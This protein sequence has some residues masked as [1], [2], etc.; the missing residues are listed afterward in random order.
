M[1]TKTQVKA[2][3]A[4]IAPIAIEICKSKSRKVLP[5]VCIAQACCE[6]AYGTSAKMVN[7]NAIFGIKVGKSKAHF[8]TAWHDK[9]YSTKTKECYDGKTYV[10]ITDMFRAYDTIKDSV[11]DYYDMLGTCS[12]YKACIGETDAVKCITAIKNGG[13]ATSPTY[14]STI[15][16]ITDANN[17][18]QYD[19]CMTK[20][21]KPDIPAADDNSEGKFSLGQKVKV[22]AY[23]SNSTASGTKVTRTKNLVIKKILTGAKH[24]YLVYSGNTAI[25]WTEEQYMSATTIS[26]TDTYVYHTVKSGDTNS[27][28]AKQYG[29]TVANILSMNK[30]TY[31]T[32]SAGFLSVGWKLRVK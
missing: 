6:S 8:G 9:A 16:K 30:S 15:T 22:T 7:A 28:I 19:E 20:V 13:Y 25:G 18:T 2:F 3:I 21:S 32:I 24:P 27:K 14:I 4:M 17:L 29:I 26:T 23:F 5:S 1:A 10:E 11:E 31:P 12:R